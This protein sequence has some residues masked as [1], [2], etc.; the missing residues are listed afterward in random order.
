MCIS[1]TVAVKRVENEL[2]ILFQQK[3]AAV[4][5]DDL[6]LVNSKIQYK[7]EYT[8][9]NPSLLK[10]RY[11]SNQYNQNDYRVL[12]PNPLGKP[13]QFSKIEKIFSEGAEVL[14]P[15]SK[16]ILKSN[17][18]LNADAYSVLPLELKLFIPHPE[19][20]AL[21]HLFNSHRDGDFGIVQVGEICSIQQIEM[22]EILTPTQ[23]NKIVALGL[24]TGYQLIPDQKILGKPYRWND[25]IALIR[26]AETASDLSDNYYAAT[27]MFDLAYSV[28][29]S[30]TIISPEELDYLTRQISSE[31]FPLTDFESDCLTAL[32]V[33]RKRQGESFD[34]L[35]SRLKAQLTPDQ[36]TTIGKLLIEIVFSDNKCTPEEQKALKRAFSSLGIDTTISDT[37]I[38]QALASRNQESPVIIQRG[39]KGSSG[40]LIPQIT[41]E[42]H[43][44]T[45]DREKVKQIVMAS[46][47]A[48]AILSKELDSNE[49]DVPDIRGPNNIDESESDRPEMTQIRSEFPIDCLPFSK[50]SILKLEPRYYPILGQILQKGMVTEEDFIHL[51]KQFGCMPDATIAAIN[52]WT[53]E[54]FGDFIIEIDENNGTIIVN[55]QNIVQ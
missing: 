36:R 9:A 42:F 39:V 1:K 16:K 7:L 28:A 3:Y 4:Y 25:Y 52:M 32:Q 44:I 34:K 40:E 19:R 8:F 37:L 26:R 49:T 6:T 23:S 48:Q 24:D 11:S 55:S 29:I 45:I 54:E 41:P 12:L 38:A 53:D 35:A 27:M 47:Q 14:Q 10:F 15:F 21:D 50:E 17:G 51:V 20:A 18:I 13:S 33:I 30:D 22:R 5:P 31:L 43:K 2:K 46:I